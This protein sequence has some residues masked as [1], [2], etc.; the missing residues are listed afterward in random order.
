ERCND[1]RR[2]DD[3]LSFI[4]GMGSAQIREVR[5]WEIDRLEEM[6]ALAIPLIQN[7]SKGR[8]E[9]YVRLREQARVQFESRVQRRPIHEILE[10]KPDFGLYQLPE[11]SEGD[12]F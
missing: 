10:L 8:P 11:P 6:A 3:H 2:K 12:V 9:T 4:A 1:I 7:P 5:K